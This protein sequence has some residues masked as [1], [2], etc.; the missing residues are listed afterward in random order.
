MGPK[1]FLFSLFLPDSRD[2]AT[3]SQP[4][5]DVP[6]VLN[7]FLKADIVNLQKAFPYKFDDYSQLGNLSH[8]QNS[9]SAFNINADLQILE[10]SWL[11]PPVNKETGKAGDWKDFTEFFPSYRYGNSVLPKAARLKHGDPPLDLPFAYSHSRTQP[12]SKATRG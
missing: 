1:T 5:M 6:S 7:T 10:Q 3:S 2:D 4:L 12:F 9:N 11:S 8:S